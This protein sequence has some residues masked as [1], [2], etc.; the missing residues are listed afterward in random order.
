M[1]WHAQ[2]SGGYYNGIGPVTNPDAIDNINMIWSYL[3]GN[4]FTR[5][6]AAGIMGNMT[7]ESGLNPWRWENDTYNTS[8][9]YGLVQYTP[10]SD[11][12]N[13]TGIPDHAPNLS[14]S[15]QTPGASPSDGN[16]QLY[17]FVND[18]LGKWVNTCWRSYWNP[19]TYPTLYTQ[20]THILNTYG[21]GTSLSIAQFATITDLADATFAFLACFEGPSVPNYSSRLTAAQHVLDAMGGGGTPLDI[22]FMKKFFIDRQF[23]RR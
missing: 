15:I 12:I 22:L 9:G 10:G 1:A 18:T 8:Y 17:V 5:E 13:L 6:A 11:Y 7:A 19:S 3:S 20:H 21:S 4:G 14:T 2:P 16:G 23:K